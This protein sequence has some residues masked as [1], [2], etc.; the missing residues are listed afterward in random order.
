MVPGWP[1]CPYRSSYL[2]RLLDGHTHRMRDERKERPAVGR[3]PPEEAG[4]FRRLASRMSIRL[5]HYHTHRREKNHYRDGCD[6]Q[7]RG[8]HVHYNLSNSSIFRRIPSI[9]ITRL[10]PINTIGMEV[11]TTLHTTDSG[12]GKYGNA[13]S[14]FCIKEMYS[15]GSCNTQTINGI[16]DPKDSVKSSFIQLISSLVLS[17]FATGRPCT[18][19]YASQ[20]LRRR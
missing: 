8:F 16:K 10:P 15:E 19:R 13:S 17:I 9:S 18:V 5:H 11:T 12:D 1:E 7:S 3:P 20:R 6:Y 14:R 4:L 2:T